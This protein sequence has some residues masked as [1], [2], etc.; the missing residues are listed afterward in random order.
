[1]SAPL[2]PC[3][4]G[5]C[6]C[7]I[8]CCC[9]CCVAS[10]HSCCILPIILVV[11]AVHQVHG[12]YV[13]LI[14]LSSAFVVVAQLTDLGQGSLHN[15]CPGCAFSALTACNSTRVKPSCSLRTTSAISAKLL[16]KVGIVKEK[17][18]FVR[19]VTIR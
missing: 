13:L 19:C 14:N 9:H 5:I 16:H 18:N 2:S 8:C 4:C 6:C 7:I 1:M 15:R 11:M 10:S 3:L 17:T 12:L